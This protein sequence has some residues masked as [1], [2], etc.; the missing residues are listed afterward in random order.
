[1]APLPRRGAPCGAGRGC[2]WRSMLMKVLSHAPRLL[3]AD[4]AQS[5]R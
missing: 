3:Y 2:A 4:V 5:Y 1:M